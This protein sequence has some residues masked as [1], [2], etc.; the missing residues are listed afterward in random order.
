MAA[1]GRRRAAVWHLLGGVSLR[2]GPLHHEGEITR[3]GDERGCGP[4]L[5]H[6]L[7]DVFLPDMLGWTVLSQLKQDPETRHIPVQIVTLDEDRQHGLAGGAFSFMSKPTTTEGL[8][9][10]LS[11]LRDFSQP[12]RR[13]LLVVEDNPAERHGITE[14]LGHDDIDIAT[15]ETGAGALARHVLVAL[16]LRPDGKKEVIDFRLAAAESAAQWEHFLGDLVRRG[17]VGERLEMLC[18][19][20]GTGLLAA[21]PTAFPDIPVQRCWAH[22]IRNVLGQALLTRRMGKSRVIAETGAGQHGVASATAAAYLGLECVVYMGEVDTQRQSLNVARMKLLGARVIAPR[23]ARDHGLHAGNGARYFTVD[24]E[25]ASSRWRDFRFLLEQEVPT[26]S[27]NRQACQAA[28][29]TFQAL[30]DV[31]EPLLHEHEA[32]AI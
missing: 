1:S 26:P 17:L 14:L 16:G 30:L 3:T 19:D 5:A 7:R 20:G 18:V 8:E 32:R 13:R 25:R 10:A 9:T 27:G 22:K 6:E 24:P 31:F 11:R 4:T 15:A 29:A 12:R 23:L 21:L 28:V 2:R